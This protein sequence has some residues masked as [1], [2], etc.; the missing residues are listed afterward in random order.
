MFALRGLGEDATVFG[1]GCGRGRS[2]LH[3][4]P[5]LFLFCSI[6]VYVVLL[7]HLRLLKLNFLLMFTTHRAC[8]F[9]RLSSFSVLVLTLLV[10]VASRG[11]GAGDVLLLFT[12]LV[13]LFL[14]L[15]CLG[16]GHCTRGVVVVFSML[17]LLLVLGAPLASGMALAL[18][19]SCSCFSP[20]CC[21]PRAVT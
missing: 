8:Q 5:V 18:S 19:C 20:F 21:F 14:C 13:L 6:F 3:F 17:S 1:V 15:L 2:G 12:I 7:V 4:L 11:R 16:T 10:A 9:F